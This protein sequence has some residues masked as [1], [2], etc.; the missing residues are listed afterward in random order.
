LRRVGC[1]EQCRCII[2]LCWVLFVRLACSVLIIDTYCIICSCI[3]FCLFDVGMI[4]VWK[5]ILHGVY[6]LCAL[7]LLKHHAYSYTNTYP[8]TSPMPI[9]IQY[10]HTTHRYRRWW[11]P[12]LDGD[13][14]VA[15]RHGSELLRRGGRDPRHAAPAQEDPRESVRVYSSVCLCV[16]PS[17]CLAVWLSGCLCLCLSRCLSLYLLWACSTC[18]ESLL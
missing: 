10:S 14:G 9:R 8:Y 15:A 6:V 16:C 11:Q 4:L 7:N 3:V 5:K 18:Y 13:V 12:W 17:V 2:Y 1:C